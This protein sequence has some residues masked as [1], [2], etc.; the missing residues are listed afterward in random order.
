MIRRR[1]ARGDT[2]GPVRPTGALR[3]SSRVTPY[4]LFMLS[5][6]IWAILTLAAE[7]TFALSD[8]TAAILGYGDTLVCGIFFVDFLHSLAVAPD[9]WRYMRSWGW[10]DLL[11]SIPAVDALRVGRMARIFRI[12]R[13]IRGVK[14]AREIIRYVVEKRK[15]SALLATTLLCVVMVTLASV[16]ILQFEVPAGGNILTAQ[17]A[18]WWSLSTMSTLGYGDVYPTT[19]EGRVIAVFLMCAGVGV[20]GTMAGLLANWFLSAEDESASELAEIKAALE[21]MNARLAALSANRSVSETRPRSLASPP[22]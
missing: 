15:E 19:P 10:I 18:V 11:S 3:L 22:A 12:V 8:E 5:L 17:D 6:S 20:F 14:S 4:E 1:C 16:A 2:L 13:V 9:R 7:A 21:Q